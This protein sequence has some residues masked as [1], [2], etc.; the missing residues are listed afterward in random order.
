MHI[1]VSVLRFFFILPSQYFQY[2][3]LLYRAI[4]GRN[5]DNLHNVIADRRIQYLASLKFDRS[6]KDKQRKIVL[7]ISCK[8]NV[9]I[10]IGAL[11]DA[12][13]CIVERM[14]N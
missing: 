12:L 8:V 13:K 7:L 10:H 14:T 5:I 2:S 9:V 4:I 3:V 1:T 11:S 6:G